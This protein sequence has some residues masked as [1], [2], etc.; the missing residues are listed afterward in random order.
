MIM[1]SYQPETD[2]DRPYD[3]DRFDPYDAAL[4]IHEGL[5]Q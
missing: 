1:A 5:D 2:I 4:I 3:V